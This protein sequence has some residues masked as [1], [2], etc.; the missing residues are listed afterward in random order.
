MHGARERQTDIKAGPAYATTLSQ[1]LWGRY[2]LLQAYRAPNTDRLHYLSLR[3]AL[4]TTAQCILMF[5][6]GIRTIP[7]EVRMMLRIYRRGR[8]NIVEIIFFVIKVSGGRAR[9]AVRTAG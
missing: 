7:G 4:P 6:E 1:L 5:F 8:P 2:R 9:R 3:A